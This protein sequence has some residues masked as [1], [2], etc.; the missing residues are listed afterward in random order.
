MAL[1]DARE[2][3]SAGSGVCHTDFTVIARPRGYWK[4]EPL[5][6]RRKTHHA[7]LQ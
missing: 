4:D 5:A 6:A 7:S 3:N 1:D 2:P